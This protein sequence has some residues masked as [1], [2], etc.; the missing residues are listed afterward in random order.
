MGRERKPLPGFIYDLAFFKTIYSQLGESLVSRTL[1]MLLR[2]NKVF[3]LGA[4]WE[5]IWGWSTLLSNLEERLVKA[6]VKSENPPTENIV[7]KS[8]KLFL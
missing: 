8:C 2:N 5:W 4:H 7:V 1:W 6:G 3:S